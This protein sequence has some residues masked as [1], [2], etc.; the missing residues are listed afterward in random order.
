VGG[1]SVTAAPVTVTTP[2]VKVTLGPT[3]GFCS[4]NFCYSRS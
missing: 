1:W 3:I 4:G 2:P